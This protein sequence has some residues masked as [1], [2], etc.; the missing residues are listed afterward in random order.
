[1][2]NLGQTWIF[3]K[4]GWPGQKVTLLTR[5]NVTQ[6]TRMIW[7]GCNTDFYDFYMLV[8]QIIPMYFLFYMLWDKW[9]HMYI[10]VYGVCSDV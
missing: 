10:L 5:A 1:M 7:P 9:V 2:Q 3:Y 6:L 4:A 8:D